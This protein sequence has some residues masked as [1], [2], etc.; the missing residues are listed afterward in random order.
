MLKD[1][2]TYISACQN[3]AINSLMYIPL[4]AAIV[5]HIYRNNRRKDCPIPKTLT[6]VYTQLCLTLLQRY[7]KSN[8]PQDRT[9]L[10][11]FSDLPS[12]YYD[13]FKQLAQLA[14]EQ[15]V[16]HNAVFYSQDVPKELVHFGF[17]D[18]V[19]SLY[20]GGVVSYNFLHLT[21]QEFLAAYHITQLSNGIDVFN[22][23]S[24][25][26]RWEVVWRF[27][28][29]LTGFK[30]FEN[31]VQNPGFSVAY[32][33]EYLE[34]TN[35]FL[36]CIFE[37][38]PKDTSDFLQATGM[39]TVYSRHFYTSL[40]DKYA[41]GYCIA[42]CSS[43]VKWE[44]R[45]EGYSDEGFMWGLNSNKSANGIISRLSSVNQESHLDYYPLRIL[46]TIEHLELGYYSFNDNKVIQAMNNLTSLSLLHLPLES[47]NF[48]N[49]VC[50]PRLQLLSI[51]EKDGRLL[52]ITKSF[53][54]VLF[55]LSSLVELTLINCQ[56]E[57][58]S[59]DSLETNKNLTKVSLSGYIKAPPFH[60]LSKILRN[61]TIQKLLI[62]VTCINVNLDLEQL[63]TFNTA[64]LSNKA[65]EQ[66]KLVIDH[67]YSITESCTYDLSLITDSRV[68]IEYKDSG[69]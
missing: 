34:V 45:M 6:Q 31:C 51:G 4:N 56:F 18:S 22:C 27:A 14:F 54:D 7:L 1:F 2:L 20:G 3:P 44:V 32:P 52:R 5:V 25:D 65:L 68:T 11:K 47:E 9:I 49:L 64:L 53:C 46:H 50:L 37:G 48:S 60:I 43:R 16:K 55:G 59:L 23:H 58:N 15:F 13:N 26:R 19:S 41:L 12:T 42:N 17:L 10:E 33:E 24:K 62:G 66:L 35:L 57:G 8:D 29:G 69:D 38:Q 40:L 30:Y 63:D 36:H 28:S 61:K 39:K 67:K 21:I